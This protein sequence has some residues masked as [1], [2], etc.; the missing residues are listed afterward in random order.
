[1]GEP[2]TPD[3]VPRPF[4]AEKNYPKLGDCILPIDYT[5]RGITLIGGLPSCSSV[6]ETSVHVPTRSLAVVCAATSLGRKTPK[7]RADVVIKGRD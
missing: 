4:P 3:Q 1:V 7:I 2:Q 6:M 5:G